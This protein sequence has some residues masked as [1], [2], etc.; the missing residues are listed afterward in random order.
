MRPR[1]PRWIDR[2]D[3]PSRIEAEGPAALEDLR[4]G[5]QRLGGR[6]PHAPQRVHER[7][8]VV[9]GVG[10]Q[11]DEPLHAVRTGGQRCHGVCADQLVG[12]G[13]LGLAV[14]T[15]HR[16]GDGV[17][18]EQP[19]D[20][21]DR[22]EAEDHRLRTLAPR[23]PALDTR[24]GGEAPSTASSSTLKRAIFTAVRLGRDHGS[25]RGM[26]TGCT[27]ADSSQDLQVRIRAFNFLEAQ[28]LRYGDTLPWSVLEEGFTFNDRRVPLIGPQGICRSRLPQSCKAVRGR[29]TTVLMKTDYS[30]TDT[31]ERIPI[32]ATTLVCARAWHGDSR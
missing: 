21:D 14:F 25:P 6:W 22:D 10:E 31:A 17:R 19:G 27:V 12:I 23:A 5:R 4:Q 30:D 3:G 16:R 26:Y 2:H 18:G 15:R 24:H 11:R 20:D 8:L 13:Q 7:D 9:L 28:R 29:T 32:I 1:G